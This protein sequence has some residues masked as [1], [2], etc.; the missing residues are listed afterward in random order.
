MKGEDYR[1][2]VRVFLYTDRQTRPVILITVTQLSH[3]LR[4]PG[5]GRQHQEFVV[6]E[7]KQNLELSYKKEADG[8]KRHGSADAD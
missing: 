5:T 2:L 1:E 7:G 4:N 6:Y 8:V 3:F